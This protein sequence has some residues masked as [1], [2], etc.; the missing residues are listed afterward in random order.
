[1]KW[2]RQKE[3][4]QGAQGAESRGEGVSE[5]ERNKKRR[6][7]GRGWCLQVEGIARARGGSRQ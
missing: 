1:V 3:G 6:C 7:G 4:V 2:N 5:G